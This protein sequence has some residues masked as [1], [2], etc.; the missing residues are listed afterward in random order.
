M[1][2]FQMKY[3]ITFSLFALIILGN[4]FAQNADSTIIKNNLQVF[5]TAEK[6]PEFPGGEEAMYQFLFKNIR[7]SI[8]T[9]EACTRGIIYIRFIVNKDGKIISPEIARPV[10]PKLH[11]ELMR[12]IKKMPDWIPGQKDGE[13]VDCW[14]IL[15]ISFNVEEEKIHDFGIVDEIPEFLGGTDELY[16]FFA[17][18]LQYSGCDIR[19]NVKLRGVIN[20]EGKAEKCKIIKSLHPDLDA[21]VLRLV[22]I[23]P[24]W[25]AGKL[26]GKPVN[27]YIEFTIPFHI[28]NGKLIT[29][30]AETMPEFP[31]GEEEMFAFLNRNLRYPTETFEKGIQGIVVVRFMINEKGKIVSPEIIHSVSSELDREVM[32]FVSIMPDWI[33]GQKDGKNVDCW[34]TLSVSFRTSNLFN[35]LGK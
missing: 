15:P 20:S 9:L 11:R 34:Y 5:L 13:N 24:V 2:D 18:N 23:M 32:R 3:K 1:F 8:K 35:F 16:V 19:G 33:P 28:E 7:Y 4:V 27:V 31:G 14:Y 21:E 6:M 26:N 22:N 17:K 12:L 29:E 25:K 30:Y 10:F